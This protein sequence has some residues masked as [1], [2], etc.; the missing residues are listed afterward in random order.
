[1][2]IVTAFDVL[3]FTDSVSWTALPLA[4]PWGTSTLTW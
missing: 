2:A 1:M 3:P 4:A